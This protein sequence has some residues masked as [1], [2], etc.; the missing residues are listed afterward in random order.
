M[1]MNLNGIINKLVGTVMRE[2][3]K[4]LSKR[5]KT[6]P[7]KKTAATKATTSVQNGARDAAKRARK[8]AKVTR[9]IGR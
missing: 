8:A 1:A 9:R 4:A 2:A 7:A 3:T 6:T 5:G